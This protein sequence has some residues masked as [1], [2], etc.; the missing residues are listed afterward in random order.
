MES[1][2]KTIY[3][4]QM[5]TGT[6]PARV[7]RLLTRYEYSH[8]AMALERD[9]KTTFSFGRRHLYHFWDGGFVVEQQNGPFFTR[10][11]KTSCRIYEIPVTDRQYAFIQYLLAGRMIHARDYKYDFLGIFLRSFHIPVAFE[12]KAVCSQFVA[13]ILEEGRVAAFDKPSCFVKPRDFESCG[14]FRT[15]YEGLYRDYRTA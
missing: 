13:E 15:I 8:V 9:C 6:M 14:G 4:L 3:V 10:F 1:H 11:P 7:I 2:S 5:H 12:N